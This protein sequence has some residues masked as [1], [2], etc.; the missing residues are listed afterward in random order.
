MNLLAEDRSSTNAL[1]PQDRLNFQVA[2]PENNLIGIEMI[3]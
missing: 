2:I 3:T 1:N